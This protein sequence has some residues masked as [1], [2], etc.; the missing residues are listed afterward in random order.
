[1]RVP[2]T[3]PAFSN[4]LYARYSGFNKF[5]FAFAK[6][7]DGDGAVWHRNPSSGGFYIPLLSEG[8]TASFYLDFIAWKKNQVYCLDTKQAISCRMRLLES[9]STSERMARRDSTCAS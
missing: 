1:M 6:A 4:G 5:E 2:K 7:L 9:Y 3:A 8:D